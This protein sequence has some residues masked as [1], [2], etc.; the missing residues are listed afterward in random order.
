MKRVK[1]L[2][3]CVFTVLTAGCDKT[4][5]A[6]KPDN[7][8]KVLAEFKLDLTDKTSEVDYADVAYR[9]DAK[10]FDFIFIDGKK[11]YD[12][13]G[14]FVDE[15]KNVIEEIGSNEYK[16]EIGS[17]TNWASLEITTEDTFYYVSWISDTYLYIKA[18]INR[19]S[20]MQKI[21]K[22]LGY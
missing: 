20:D 22:K 10:A 1:I 5:T 12:I 11:K 3:L 21:V 8:K 13:E 4:K 6:I 16:Q 18:P 17:G 9:V 2:L 14:L 15:C 19:S 7:F